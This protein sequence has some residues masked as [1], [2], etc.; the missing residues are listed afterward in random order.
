MLFGALIQSTGI[1]GVWAYFLYYESIGINIGFFGL[2]FAGWQLSSAFG[3]RYAHSLEN[4]VGKKMAL[5][6]SLL[7]APTFLLLGML[8][9]FLLIPLIFLNAFL[10]G[11]V[12]PLLLDYMN[13]IIKS[14]V[15][16]TTLS[17]I[18]MT[19][20]LSFVVIS[21]IFGKLV[22]SFSLSTA[23]IIMGIYFIVFGGIA[24][25]KVTSDLFGSSQ[26]DI[27]EK[28]EE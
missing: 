4:K 3:G 18:N 27:K 22:D 1:T 8:K 23:F 6:L 19:G 10:W 28:R 14:E 2:I 24:S 15:R 26:K 12:F 11:F 5:F 17:V 9:T 20:S 16:A 21:P 25:F 13:R 7:I